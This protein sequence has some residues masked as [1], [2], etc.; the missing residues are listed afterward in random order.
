MLL[1]AFLTFA[2]QVAVEDQHA[3][4]EVVAAAVVVVTLVV[5]PG[6]E[7]KSLWYELK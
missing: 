5:V 2:E 3:V 4:A 1:I 7:R 6:V